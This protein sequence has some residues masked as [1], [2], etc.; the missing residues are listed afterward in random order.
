MPAT[1]GVPGSPQPAARASLTQMVMRALGTSAAED[2]NDDTGPSERARSRPGRATTAHD[3]LAEVARVRAEL[4]VHV[5]R[6]RGAGDVEEDAERARYVAAAERAWRAPLH[7]SPGLQHRAAPKSESG[8]Q[9][10]QRDD[11]VEWAQ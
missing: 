2:D 11:A 7:R 1:V 8:R 3:R 6:S 10:D 4:L 5:A 9:A